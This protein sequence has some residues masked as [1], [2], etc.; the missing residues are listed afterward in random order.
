MKE[1]LESRLWRW[2]GNCVPA[3]R[4]SGA[5]VTF[6][7]ACFREV[8]IK[9]PCSWRTKNHMNMTWG[10]SLYAALDPIYAVILYKNLGRRYRVVDSQANIR[11]LRPAKETLYAQFFIAEDD[12]TD[13]RQQLTLAPT[14]RRTYRI[15]WVNA[16][17]EVHA[18]CVKEVHIKALKKH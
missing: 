18:E 11:F 10:G 15:E 12:V 3:Y 9:L 13:I 17:G 7:S 4:G 5:R 16:A 8:H 1:S 14:V 6:V 2:L